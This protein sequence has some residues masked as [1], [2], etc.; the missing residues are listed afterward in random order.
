[1]VVI[2]SVILVIFALEISIAFI[3][4][5]LKH[6]KNFYHLIS[7]WSGFVFQFDPDVGYGHK[8]NL[9]HAKPNKPA[10]N[11]PRR[12]CFGDFRTDKYGFVFRE[13]LSVL[14][15]N[16]RLMFCIGGSTTEGAFSPP[17]KTYPAL[18]DSFVKGHGYRCINA[19][20]GGY[21]SIH[22]LLYF[23]K[24]I[25]PWKPWGI[26]VFSGYNDFVCPVY[27]F[28]NPYDPFKHSFSDI[29]PANRLEA[30]FRSTAT[31]SFVKRF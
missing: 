3:F 12:I 19:G 4:Y 21:R 29:M 23:K 24:K 22:E 9:S 16:N 15:K 6:G 27:G 10:V 14:K 31:F 1:M 20:V 17:D 2:L 13:D 28:S 26:I 25:L 30:I 5:P 18:L 7:A 11:A 8:P